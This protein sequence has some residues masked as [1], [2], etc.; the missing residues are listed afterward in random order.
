MPGVPAGSPPPALSLPP[1]HLTPSPTHCILQVKCEEC[2]HACN[3][4]AC[5]IK[6]KKSLPQ[7]P[8]S[9][10]SCAPAAPA[11]YCLH[12]TQPKVKV[13]GENFNAAGAGQGR[14]AVGIWGAEL[15][16]WTGGGGSRQL[17]RHTGSCQHGGE[18]GGVAELLVLN[19]GGFGEGTNVEYL[20]SV[21]SAKCGSS[22]QPCS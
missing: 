5:L 1:S 16:S 15:G 13:S 19:R 8:C 2:D 18:G 17:P 10:G 12:C 3:N 21:V 4:S 20:P 11:R 14:A 22:V 7:P 6:H 9:S